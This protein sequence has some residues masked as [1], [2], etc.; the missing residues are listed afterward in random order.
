MSE[1]AQSRD[2]TQSSGASA[3]ELARLLRNWHAER[4]SAALYAAL[5]QRARN[6][7]Q[8]EVYR[9][10]TA[11]ES[12][13][14][15]FWEE[16]LRRAGQALPAY[17]PGARTRM[18]IALV[19][20]LGAAPVVPSI[21]VREMRDRDG[22]RGQADAHTAGLAAEEQGHAALLRTATE[23]A[24]GNNLRAAVLGANDGLTSIFCLM[25][26]VAGSGASTAT[27][28]LA[29]AAGLV[30]G[31]GAMA[32]GEWL[33]V[34]NAREL[35]Q[36]LIDREAGGAG[37]GSGGAERGG[38]EDVGTSHD[39]AVAAGF[40]FLLFALGALV[41]LLPL[42][43]LPAVTRV[44]GSALLS[45]VALFVLGVATSLFNARPALYSG[46][47]QMAI[48]AATAAVTYLAGHV[49]AVLAAGRF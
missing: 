31:A 2:G 34:T 9:Q 37:A 39:A 11:A 4:D 36:S 1:A 5:A 3:P 18:L 15:G 10:L 48:G 7:R 21:I 41:P 16:R 42:L 46:A 22:Y 38:G 24:F 6:P 13:H 26:G 8:R 23:R 35:E 17:H 19:R 20:C 25:M 44:A 14:A 32:M 12:R 28:A 30:S 29:G 49:F 45:L 33:S 27:I 43:L 40:S 47:R